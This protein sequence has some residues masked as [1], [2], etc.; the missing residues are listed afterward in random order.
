MFSFFR[1]DSR[2]MVPKWLWQSLNQNAS[3]VAKTRSILPRTLRPIGSR[4]MG[5][6]P[7]GFDVVNDLA[8][9]FDFLAKSVQAALKP[10]KS[11]LRFRIYS[12]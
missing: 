2:D 5:A 7:T 11:F 8:R 3:P 1:V 4:P 12:K 6:R 10:T 9:R